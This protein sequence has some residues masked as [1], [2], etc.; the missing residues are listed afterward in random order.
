MQAIRKKWNERYEQVYAPNQ[1]ID[2]LELNGHLLPKQGKSLDLACG[3]G[4][5]ALRLAELGLESH[6]WDISDAAVEKVQE[7]ARERHLTI[8]TRQCDISQY[9]VQQTL[10]NEGFDV[11]VVGHFLLRGVIPSLISAL[12]PG[13]LIFYQTFIEE[14]IDSEQPIRS[15]PTNKS[16]RLKKNE[17]LQLFPGLTLRYY[18]EDGILGNQDKGVRNEAL[19]VAEK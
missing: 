10:H 6:A 19:L 8:A 17:L 5:N 14:Q 16:F 1:V 9:D 12:K 15:G 4:G 11:I 18:R 7:F 13:G 2:V 3:L